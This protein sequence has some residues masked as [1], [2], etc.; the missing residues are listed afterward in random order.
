V[1]GEQT[2]RVRL[3]IDS[4]PLHK[5]L[6]VV[7]VA[8]GMTQ[9]QLIEAIGFKSLS[10]YSMIEQGKRPVPLYLM[11]RIEQFLYEEESE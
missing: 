2:K 9:T 8:R 5:Q 3:D 6:H 4:M 10:K 1:K 7:R 11:V